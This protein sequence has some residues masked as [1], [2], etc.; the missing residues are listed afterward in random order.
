M[1]SLYSHKDEEVLQTPILLF[2]VNRADGAAFRW[3]THSVTYNGDAYQPLV[4]SHGAFHLHLDTDLVYPSSDTLSLVLSNADGWLD[5]Q[6]NPQIWK[7]TTIKA[8][9]LFYDLSA[10]TAGEDSRILFTGICQGIDEITDTTVRFLFHSRL[11]V[12]RAYVPSTPLQTRCPWDFPADE[13]QRALAASEYA[14]ETYSPLARCGYS[15]DVPGG[16]GNSNDSVPY[17]SCNRTRTDCQVRGMLDMDAA[18]NPTRRFAGIDLSSIDT[19]ENKKG[20][21]MCTVVP[22]VYGTGWVKAPIMRVI[23]EGHLTRVYA[24]VS[25]G[26]IHGIKRISVNRCEIPRKEP[27]LNQDPTGWYSLVSTGQREGTFDAEATDT[28]PM[29]PFGSFAYLRISVPSALLAMNTTITV[30]ALIDG[31]RLPRFN[32]DGALESVDFTS[33]PVWVTLDLLRRAG[34][35]LA[36]IS[37]P[38]F[39]GVAE[40]CDQL[41]DVPSEDGRSLTI[42]MRRCNLILEEPTSITDLL[43]GISVATGLYLRHESDGKVGLGIESSLAIQ[44]PA[45]PPG[46]NCQGPLN[47]GY[48]AYEFGDGTN[49]SGGIARR[50]NGQPSLRRWSNPLSESV[51]KAWTNYIDEFSGFRKNTITLSEVDDIL[52]TGQELSMSLRAIGLS[53]YAHAFGAT[54]RFLRK[55][56]D[57]NVFVEFD[58]SVRAVSLQPGD[59]VAISYPKFGLNRTPFRIVRMS[60]GLNSAVIKILAQ[61][62]CDEWYDD[63]GLLLQTSIEGVRPNTMVPKP[64]LGSIQHT[65]GST[66]FDLEEQEIQSQ[67]GANSALIAQFVHPNRLTQSSCPAPRFK[68]EAYTMPAGN[69]LADTTYYY[70]LCGIDSSGAFTQL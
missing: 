21:A 14:A 58:T 53:N 41:I 5:E 4:L 24:A 30:E 43:R 42:T 37:L 27:N 7:G 19:A 57:G 34:W 35:S 20:T 38:S 68:P 25:H 15:A 67:D 6:L 36:D 33:N 65:D 39:Y 12:R 2:D 31:L 1:A 23:R 62:H 52:A 8:R 69:L 3:S 48:P 59:L 61:L 46:S 56:I 29:G 60:V 28:L 13:A 45:V 17:T 70:A 49:G 40:R 10:A 64:I 47:G 66:D 26:P 9:F 18:G 55:R 51:N 11:G 22:I 32:S 54:R 63:S 16:R 50:A 44:H